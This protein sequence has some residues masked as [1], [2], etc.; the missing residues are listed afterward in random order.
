VLDIGIGQATNST[1]A[2][3]INGTAFTKTT[4]TWV[5]GS[6]N[7]GLGTGLTLAANT[8]YAV[9]AA[10]ISGAY[11]VFFDTVNPPTHQP[12]GTTAYRRLGWIRTD[13]SSNII[14]FVQDGEWFYLGWSAISAWG[15]TASAIN[16]TITAWPPYTKTV[17]TLSL[18]VPAAGSID[19]YYQ[20][21]S[22]T[23]S[24]HLFSF[25]NNTTVALS[26]TINP[27]PGPYTDATGSI[28]VVTSVVGSGGSFQGYNSG[29][30]DHRG[31]DDGN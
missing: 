31:R 16:L 15:P 13:A 25:N 26:F 22:A 11:D 7:G 4:A 20:P 17:T 21:V 3:I 1:N 12:A 6:G 28:K 2:S 8:F 27:A 10:T 19:I 9:F 18:T 30:I 14:K 23:T 5:A 29:W 24:Q